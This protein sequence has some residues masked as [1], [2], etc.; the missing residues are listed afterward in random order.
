MRYSALPGTSRHHWGT[1]LD[2]Y[3]AAALGE[4]QAVQ[5]VPEEVAPGGVFDPLHCWLDERMA[6]GRSHGFFRPY[7]VDRGG[8]AP[9]RWHLSYAPL[10]LECDRQFSAD[11]LRACWDRELSRDGMLLSEEVDS[12]LQEILQRYVAVAEDWCPAQW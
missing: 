12:A 6:A 7:G 11:L 10:A 1:D 3:D 5:L 2:I 9:E 4:R 8:V